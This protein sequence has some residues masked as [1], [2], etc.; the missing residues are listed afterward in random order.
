MLI[1]EQLRQELTSLPEGVVVTASDFDIPLQYR[2]A[3]TKALNQ[4]ASAGKLKRLSKGRYYKPRQSVFGEIGPS[5]NELIKDFLVKDGK[6]IGYITGVRAFA[7]LGLTTQIASS[8]TIGTNTPRR[9]VSRGR[10]RLSFLFQPNPITEED[11]PLFRYLDALKCIKNIP[12]SSPNEVITTIRAQVKELP[13]ENK[14]RLL[15]LSFA[16]QPH[17]RALVGAIFESI[18]LFSSELK[19]TLNPVSRY[20]LGISSSVLSTAPNW[21]I[22]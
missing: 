9:P 6:T 14:D 19:E 22:V 1:R 11:I 3:L 12:A 17:V 4:F 16:Y 10:L 13:K 2:G 21:N 18:G 5:E 7:S 8:I 15:S 20:K